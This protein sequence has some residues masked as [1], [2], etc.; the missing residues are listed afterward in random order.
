[1]MHEIGEELDAFLREARCPLRV[2][3]GPERTQTTAMG[4]E[5]IVIEH[6][7]DTG[8]RF[9]PA[10]GQHRN[11]RHRMTRV[12]GGKLTIYVQSGRTGAMPFEHR[13]RA[14]HVLDLVL[15][16]L[17]K[18]IA[19]RQA[20]SADDRHITWSPVSGRFVQP[21]DL[22]ASEHR[23][24]AVYELR[25]TFDHGVRVLPWNGELAPEATIGGPNGVRIRSTTKVSLAGGEGVDPNTV[26]DE[27]ETSCGA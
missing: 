5:R 27:A 23:N 21:A 26:P 8:D 24:G 7:D 2:I 20:R 1:M 17:E 16:G 18:V 14:Q 13:R 15:V 22:E 9:A 6:D 11:P 10:R 3:D 25:F 12:A 4:R 19:A